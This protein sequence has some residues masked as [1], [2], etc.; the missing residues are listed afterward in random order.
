MALTSVGILYP[1]QQKERVEVAAQAVKE[2]LCARE[3]VAVADTGPTAD[4]DPSSL[5]TAQRSF[6]ISAHPSRTTHVQEC[7]A[8]L[9]EDLASVDGVHVQVDSND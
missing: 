8:A 4:A 1:V 5:S 3:G 7:L 9:Q 6:A 2:L